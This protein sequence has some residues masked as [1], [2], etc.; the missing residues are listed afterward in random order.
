MPMTASSDDQPGQLG[1]RGGQQRQ[2]DPQEA[3]GADLVEHADQQRAGADRRFGTGVGQPGVQR[4]QR[5]LDGEGDG[6][7]GEDP[8]LGRH[9]DLVRDVAQRRPVQRSTEAGRDPR[10]HP[11]GGDVQPDDRGQHQQATDQR[12]EEEL[13]RR[14]G[15]PD[16]AERPDQEVH[17]DEHDLEHDVEHEHVGGGEDARHRRLHDQDQREVAADRAALRQLLLPGR[18]EHDRNQE[19]DQR[20][21]HQRDAV[22][23]EGEADSERRDP[24][25]RERLGERRTG[26][27]DRAGAGA[28]T[29]LGVPVGHPQRGRND[30]STREKPMAVSFTVR[31]G[32]LPMAATTPPRPA[33]GTP[34]SAGKGS[35][36]CEPHHQQGRDRPGR[37]RTASTGR[38]SGRI[39]SASAAIA[40][41]AHRDRRPTR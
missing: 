36:S 35:R 24:V 38:T 13:G 6:E 19:R 9:R 39:R 15:A 14:V 40:R 8:Q 21:H 11:T 4:H 41:T 17:R 27:R 7:P 31:A 18:A 28:Q 12:V 29:G 2:T 34:G 33:A 5:R 22:H 25:H 16:P 3:E 26:V 10:R 1:R 23:A 32:D 30:S 37:C 20:D